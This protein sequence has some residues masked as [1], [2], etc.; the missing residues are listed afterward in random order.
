MTREEMMDNVIKKYGFESEEAIDFC[1][2]A[3]TGTTAMVELKYDFYM[4]NNIFAE[5]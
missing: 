2:I 5:V 3:E 4:K 1:R